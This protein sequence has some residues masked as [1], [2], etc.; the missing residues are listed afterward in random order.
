MCRN[1]SFPL[2]CLNCTHINCY[3][4][5]DSIFM[6]ASVLCLQFSGYLLLFT[7]VQRIFVP[8][9]SF[10]HLIQSQHNFKWLIVYFQVQLWTICSIVFL[11]NFNYWGLFQIKTY[12]ASVDKFPLD[13]KCEILMDCSQNSCCRLILYFGILIRYVEK[14]RNFSFSKGLYTVFRQILLLRKSQ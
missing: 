1:L 8:E 5:D 14:K 12:K 2:F 7:V 4:N 13:Y 6:C 3:L 10:Q 11:F 9:P